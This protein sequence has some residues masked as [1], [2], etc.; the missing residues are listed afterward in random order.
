[1]TKESIRARVRGVAVDESRRKSL[2]EVRPI[3]SELKRELSTIY[4]SRLK[5]LLIYGSYARG[6]AEEGSDL[7][8]MVV[9]EDRKSVV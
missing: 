2:E 9:L 1:M 4:G 5:Y 6:E 8:L 3:L 7:D